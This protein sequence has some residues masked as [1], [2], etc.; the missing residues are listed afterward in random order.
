MDREQADL[1]SLERAQPLLNIDLGKR[2]S[3][4]LSKTVTKTANIEK[5]EADRLLTGAADLLSDVLQEAKRDPQIAGYGLSYDATL[6]SKLTGEERALAAEAIVAEIMAGDRVILSPDTNIYDVH[7]KNTL[8]ATD[9]ADLAFAQAI[10]NMVTGKDE[11]SVGTTMGRAGIINALAFSIARGP[12]DENPVFRSNIRVEESVDNE[13]Y[14]R[15]K[16]VEFSGGGKSPEEWS[17]EGFPIVS[18][19]SQS[20]SLRNYLNSSVELRA[21]W[22]GSVGILRH[23][24]LPKPN[25]RT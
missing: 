7:S 8:Q 2:I 15:R 1:H 25:S 4:Y 3:E 11:L 22:E 23:L 12:S 14:V 5:S 18:H 19:T 17:N 20:T 10:K 24:L 6:I 9:K 21:R 13:G 16:R